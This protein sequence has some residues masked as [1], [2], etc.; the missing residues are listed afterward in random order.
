[1]SLILTLLFCTF[2]VKLSCH[3]WKYLI[4]IKICKQKISCKAYWNVKT[5]YSL[6]KWLALRAST[7][8]FRKKLC[9]DLFSSRKETREL[10]EFC[11]H[12]NVARLWSLLSATGQLW[13][14]V[15]V[16]L[17]YFISQGSKRKTTTWTTTEETTRRYGSWDRNRPPWPKFV[18]EYDDDILF[19]PR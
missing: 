6:Y 12:Q 5:W 18:T 19:L 2:K 11:K 4:A 1:V 13:L 15:T 3:L 16:P 8:T 7:F 9:F 10:S 14:H 17:G